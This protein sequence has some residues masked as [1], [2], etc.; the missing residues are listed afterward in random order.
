MAKVS[1]ILPMLALAACATGFAATGAQAQ[2]PGYPV[3]YRYQ[4][5][6]D[7]K[8]TFDDPAYYVFYR[9]YSPYRPGSVAVNGGPSRKAHARSSVRK[10]STAATGHPPRKSAYR[11]KS[12]KNPTWAEA[13]VE[14]V[15]ICRTHY[16]YWGPQRVCQ[17]MY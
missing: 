8:D 4:W 13:R 2:Q 1:K 12:P 9:P 16:T 7:E 15:T 3:N 14:P 5:T 17:R 10:A 6:L 11:M